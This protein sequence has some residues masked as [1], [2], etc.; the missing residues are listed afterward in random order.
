M[1]PVFRIAAATVLTVTLVTAAM[2]E[3]PA[4][5][6]V[7][8]SHATAWQASSADVAALT[9]EQLTGMAMDN[10]P[11]L[12][13]A[14]AQTWKAHGQ[15]VQAGLYPNTEFGFTASEVGNENN[16]GQQGFYVG[17]E[18]VTGGKL[19]ISQQ[20]AGFRQQAAGFE[21]T[22]QQLRVA[23]DV[24]LAFYQTLA[25]ARLLELADVLVQVAERG[26][27][28][29]QIRIDQQEGSK[30]DL[31]QARNERL[32]AGV[33]RKN[34]QA[35]FDAAF[36]RLAVS[37]GLP[38]LQAAPLE[39][40]LEG[41]IPDLEWDTTR[42][43]LLDQSPQLARARMLVAQSQWALE[44]ARVE[45]LPNL[46]TQ[47]SVQQD[48][49]T[50]YTIFGFQVGVEVPNHDRNQ[51]NITTAQM[52]YV[53]AC[54]DIQRLQLLLTRSLAD[55]FQTYQTNRQQTLTLRDEI[56][57]T[58]RETLQLSRTAFEAGELNFIQLLTSQRSYAEANIEYIRSL[59]E[60]WQSV[61]AIDGLLLVDGLQPPADFSDQ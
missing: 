6:S 28:L 57:P 3:E 8:G 14:R 23:N 47:A 9:L 4:D 51:G 26:E 53:R 44:R 45:P 34:A 12:A 56:L 5:K 42:S 39:G 48:F 19:Q 29:T 24:R 27:Q 54:K 43:R 60:L 50:E 13:Q 30:I 35:E 17:Q 40:Q 37:V 32:R 21:A 59:S 25:L 33:L 31:L 15:Y 46:L 22:A 38:G 2:A 16:G 20:A 61:I 7:T 55:R 49:A 52:E 18:F 36:R 10:H 58:T 1:R 41:E 11:T